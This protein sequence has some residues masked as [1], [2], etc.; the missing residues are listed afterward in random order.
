MVILCSHSLIHAQVAERRN[1]VRAFVSGLL[2]PG[3]RPFWASQ[4]VTQAMLLLRPVWYLSLYLSDVKMLIGR[5]REE[6]LACWKG[7]I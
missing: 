6:R 2:P 4:G 3:R 7:K 1:T 5:L